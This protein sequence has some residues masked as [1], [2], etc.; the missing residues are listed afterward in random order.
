[1]YMQ[2]SMFLHFMLKYE[3]L[4]FQEKIM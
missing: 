3:A 2:I 1:M 4:A